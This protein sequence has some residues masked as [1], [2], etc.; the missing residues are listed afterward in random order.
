MK[1]N[2]TLPQERPEEGSKKGGMYGK[3]TRKCKTSRTGS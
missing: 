2:L 3:T 1:E